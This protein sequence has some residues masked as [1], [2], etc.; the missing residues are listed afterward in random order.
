[1][2]QDQFE[3]LQQRAEQLIDV[4]LAESDPEAWPGHGIAPASMDKATR[5]DRVWCKRD[6]AATLSC[7]QRIAGLVDLA[8]QK[9]AGGEAT[10]GAVTN[11]DEELDREAAEAE[12]EAT[13]LINRIQG[14]PPAARRAAAKRAVNGKA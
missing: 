9:T 10:P 8:R 12:A 4:F 5:G 3:A 11:T 7:A 2:R 6:A 14:K 13:R 1:M